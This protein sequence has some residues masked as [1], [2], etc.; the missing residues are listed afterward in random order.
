MTA[1]LPKRRRDRIGMVVVAFGPTARDVL[2]QGLKDGD[3]AGPL[4]RLN[5][6]HRAK[7]LMNVLVRSAL[8]AAS[9]T[10]KANI[11]LTDDGVV[12]TVSRAIFPGFSGWSARRSL[13]SESAEGTAVFVRPFGDSPIDIVRPWSFH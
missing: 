5:P 11:W 12:S 4:L 9:L 10:Q 1:L 8:S 3:P 6:D 13:R 2:R 7:K